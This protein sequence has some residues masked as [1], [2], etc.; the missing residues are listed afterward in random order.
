M[1]SQSM[2]LKHATL[3]D[4]V[5]ASFSLNERYGFSQSAASSVD[6]Y[7][8]ADV[9]V[10]ASLRVGVVVQRGSEG[11]VARANTLYSYLELNRHVR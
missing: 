8:E 5:A 1:P 7:T 3:H 4:E 11:Y 9:E 6:E 10:S 2:S